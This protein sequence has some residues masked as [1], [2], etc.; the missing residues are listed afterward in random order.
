MSPELGAGARG[1]VC[2]CVQAERVQFLRP[3]R[4][5]CGFTSSD[6]SSNDKKQ[7]KFNTDVTCAKGFD[8]LLLSAFALYR[9]V[10]DSP[11][12]LS[13]LVRRVLVLVTTSGE[14]V[15][16]SIAVVAKA[17]LEI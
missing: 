2:G 17:S 8:I 5:A 1:D 4:A 9:F 12:L 11:A 16:T 6:L 10:V 14:D 7:E 3:S 15:L 13:N